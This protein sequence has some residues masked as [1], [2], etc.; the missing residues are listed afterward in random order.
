MSM[1]SHHRLSRGSILVLVTL[2][3]MATGLVYL[4][5]GGGSLSAQETPSRLPEIIQV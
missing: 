1:L 4:I 3:G 5:A 2:L